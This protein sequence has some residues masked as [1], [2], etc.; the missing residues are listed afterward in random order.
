MNSELYNP[1]S[2][3]IPAKLW[4][5]LR[6]NR[7]FRIDLKRARRLLQNDLG[8]YR[9]D[10]IHSL[11]NTNEIADF[12]MQYL[13][14][15]TAEVGEKVKARHFGEDTPWQHAPRRFRAQM[16]RV[17]F[18]QGLLP[19]QVVPPRF[20]ESDPHFDT[21][22]KTPG[23][24]LVSGR[25]VRYAHHIWEKFNVIAVPRVVEDDSHRTEILKELE[26]ALPKTNARELW[27]KPGGMILGTAKAWDV[28]LIWD[29]WK[30][31]V[32]ATG[33][34]IGICKLYLTERHAYD[35]GAECDFKKLSRNTSQTIDDL[36]S[37]RGADVKDYLDQVTRA[38][39]G[40]YPNLTALGRRKAP[41]N[42]PT[43]IPA[44]IWPD[45]PGHTFEYG[46]PERKTGI[47]VSTS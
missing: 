43:E 46:D 9:D 23:D 35:D 19:S 10:P 33:K 24:R 34:R 2:D 3:G 14:R 11:S 29:Y 26:K 30:D 1:C 40:T 47:R 25:W 28:F 6:R 12:A 17:V 38:I 22:S 13:L 41:R 44:E 7:R 20:I 8:K 21:D 42:K 45:T 18:H 5:C 15:E 27:F 16:Q 39:R 36:A 37:R 4:E 32:P 31:K